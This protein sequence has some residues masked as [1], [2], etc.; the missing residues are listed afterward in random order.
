MLQ[1]IKPRTMVTYYRNPKMNLKGVSMGKV[2]GLIVLALRWL[3]FLAL[4][5]CGFGLQLA[6]VAGRAVLGLMVSFM[7]LAIIAVLLVRPMEV[8]SIAWRI[9]LGFALYAGLAYLCLWLA[10]RV[11]PKPGAWSHCWNGAPSLTGD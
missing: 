7:A 9:G 5:L 4:T 8:V 1:T 6:L 3:L 11:R 2:V 10:S